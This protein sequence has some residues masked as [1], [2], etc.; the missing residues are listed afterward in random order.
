MNQFGK[1]CKDIK[2]VKIQGAT[3]IAKYALKAYYLSP[4]EKSKRI[5]LSLR[6][7]EPM[8]S[9]VMNLV[10]RAP[11]Q[12]IMGHFKKAQDIINLQ[13]FKL[14]RNRQTIFTHC[15]STNVVKALIYAKKR[16]K[17]FQV[18][19]TETRPL[20]QGRKTSRELARAGIKV[21]GWVDAA[22]DDAIKGSDIILLG[23]DAIL[24]DGVIN[25]IGS[26]AIAEIAFLRKKPV[27]VIADSWKFS[28]KNVKIEA[29]DFLEVW[30]NAP[31]KIKIMN[32]AFEKVD[33]KYIKGI[34]SEFGILG[35][36]AFIKKVKNKS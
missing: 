23:S 1:I 21:T 11:K 9:H 25:K 20:Y 32:P 27:Y 26:E 19:N 10:G 5:L 18:F 3:N 14:I 8:L 24:K 17:S 33:K 22:M 2:E 28:P 12:D 15:H 6:P 7:T 30:K 36:D 16:R 29:R 34:V 35:F 31:R 4:N 13:V